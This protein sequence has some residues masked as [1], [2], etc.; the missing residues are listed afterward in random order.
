MLEAGRVSQED[1]SIRT[2]FLASSLCIHCQPPSELCQ[3]LRRLSDLWTKLVF[4][5]TSLEG[6]HLTCTS[7]P[8][9]NFTK[10]EVFA[11][12]KPLLL[13]FIP[14]FVHLKWHLYVE[15]VWML[16]I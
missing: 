14:L 9:S 5:A 6:G 3:W 15:P 8:G 16:L 12:A 1:Y 7:L 13:L 11:E 10:A 2:L 4:A